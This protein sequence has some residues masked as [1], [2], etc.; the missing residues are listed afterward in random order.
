MSIADNLN[1]FNQQLAGTSAKLIAVSKTKPL[2]DIQ[3]A[4]AAGQ[5]AFGENKVQEM[6]EKA[7]KLPEDIQWHQIG[8]LQ[9]NKVKYIAPF[10]HLIHSV[11]SIKLMKE[12]NKQAAKNERVIDCLLQIHIAEEESK[13]GLS[14]EE[15]ADIM[16]QIAGAY[17]NLRIVGLMGMAT[18]TEDEAQVRKEFAGLKKFFDIHKTKELC[19]NVDLKEI[20]MGMSGDYQIA[21]EEGSSMVRVGSAIFG[22]RNYAV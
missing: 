11:D 10:V 9:T 6:A 5:R 2:E 14:F 20:S 7:A 12:I 17:P 13:F 21:V 4:Y 16:G 22:A 3:T 15:A 18:N 8:H 19:E 1:A